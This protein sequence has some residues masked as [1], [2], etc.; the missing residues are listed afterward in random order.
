MAHDVRA[1]RGGQVASAGVRRAPRARYLSIA[2]HGLI[3]DLHTVALV[4]TD[5]TIDWYC[6]PLRLAERL[7]GDPRRRP[8]GLFRIS[9]D[10]DGWSSKQLEVH[11]SMHSSSTSRGHRERRLRCEV[12]SSRAPVDRPSRPT[13]ALGGSHARTATTPHLAGPSWLSR[14][15]VS[16]SQVVGGVSPL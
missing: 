11:P 16:L 8:Q 7:R 2:E 13:T 1:G 5:G 4:G 14:C 6:C 9:P 10:C 15:D 3:G 12:A